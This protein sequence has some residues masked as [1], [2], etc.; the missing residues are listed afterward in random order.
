MSSNAEDDVVHRLRNHLGVIVG[1]CDLLLDGS[2]DDTQRGD[3]TAIRSTAEDAL[4]LLP[5]VA[6]RLTSD[7]PRDV[8]RRVFG[9]RDEQSEP[10]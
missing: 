10:D 4:A 7:D 6:R 9:D 5:E 2:S 1:Y 3:L 8:G